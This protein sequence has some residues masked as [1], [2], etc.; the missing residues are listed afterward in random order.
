MK[1]GYHNKWENTTT[2]KGA[3]WYWMVLIFE[4][5]PPNSKLMGITWHL[6]ILWLMG[7]QHKCYQSEYMD[8]HDL[9]K[10]SSLLN[11]KKMWD[12]NINKQKKVGQCG[13]KGLK[14]VHTPEWIHING[15]REFDELNLQVL[16]VQH[17]DFSPRRNSVFLISTEKW[18]SLWCKDKA[19]ILCGHWDTP[20][21]W[22]GVRF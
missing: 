1:F 6:W 3:Q 5:L 20:C 22:Q 18:I 2:K 21:I 11:E 16:F 12:K 13:L 4:G 10:C 17:W 15:I 14:G 19:W 9:S 8:N 7:E